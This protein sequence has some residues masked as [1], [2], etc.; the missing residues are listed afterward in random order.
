MLRIRYVRRRELLLA[1]A[2]SDMQRL[3]NKQRFILAVVEGDLVVSKKKKVD[4]EAELRAARY[5]MLPRSGKVVVGA[6]AA[7]GEDG[8]EGAA[9]TSEHVSY[10]YL[11]SMP[12]WRAAPALPRLNPITACSGVSVVQFATAQPLPCTTT[13]PP[14]VPD[15][16]TQQPLPLR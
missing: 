3:D 5:D 11:L 16:C 1:T 14:Y 9:G 4:L 12:L 13:Y 8:E 6:Q 7:E 2:R 10:D 15:K